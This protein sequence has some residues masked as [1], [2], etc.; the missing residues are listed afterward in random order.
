MRIFR[1]SGLKEFGDFRIGRDL[2]FQ[3]QGKLG[4]GSVMM[5]RVSDLQ[6]WCWL[7]FASGFGSVVM[8]AID[9]VGL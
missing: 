4:F 3:C 1:K 7:G 6:G 5:I 8:L 9:G 2:G